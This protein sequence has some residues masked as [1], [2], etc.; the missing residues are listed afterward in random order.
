VQAF[1]E[2]L[3]AQRPEGPKPLV[4][5]NAPPH[6]PRVVREAATQAHSTLA[7]LPFL[8]FLP[9]RAPERNPCEDLWRLLKAA[10]AA[11]RAYQS[12][13]ELADRALHWLDQHTPAERLRLCAVPSSKF[14]WLRT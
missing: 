2:T 11:N 1:V 13:D 7:F 9:F 6:H 3:G 10:V 14:N 5:D 12:I 8:P 4:W